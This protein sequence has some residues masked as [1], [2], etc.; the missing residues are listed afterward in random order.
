MSTPSSSPSGA[1]A[2]SESGSAP[3]WHDQGAWLKTLLAL[4]PLASLATLHKGDPAVSMVSV[5]IDPSNGDL[6]IHVSRLA[7]HTADML[8]HDGVSVMFMG[9]AAPDEPIQATPRVS[10]QGQARVIAGDAPDH[11]VA[12][13]CFLARFPDS[14]P[15]FGFGDFSLVRITPRS[16]RL[17]GGFGRATSW[18]VDRYRA[19]WAGT[20]AT[21]Q[22]D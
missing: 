22:G 4:Q 18:M 17:V 15:M 9:V 10:F 3:A 19:L 14:E 7:T 5:A 16:L 21:A 20:A 2:A 1:P 13:A 12:R 8:A 11:E 6:L